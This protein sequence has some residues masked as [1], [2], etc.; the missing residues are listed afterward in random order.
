MTRLHFSRPL[1]AAALAAGMAFLS[2][3]AASV[4]AQPPIVQ[5]GAPGEPSRT[6][7]AAEASDLAGIRFSEADVRFMQ[8][9]ISHHAQALEMTALLDVNTASDA[10]RATARRIELSQEDEIGMM[11]DWPAR[12]RPGRHRRRRAPRRGLPA[13]AGHADGRGDGE[14]RRGGGHRLRP[15]LPRADDQAPPRRRHHGREPTAPA[16][17]GAGLGALR[18]HV[19]R[20]RR[21]DGRDQ[22]HGRDDGRADPRPAG[23]ARGRFQRRRAGAVEHG[24]GGDAAQARGLLRSEQPGGAAH[25]GAARPGAGGGRGGGGRGR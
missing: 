6:I 20:R 9:M 15:A 1:V 18:V 23:A 10:M 5:P 11:Q 16:R 14:S 7:S 22:P 3:G 13:H 8:G 25:A 24:A 2:L 12:A 21:P 4:L 19:G 17:R